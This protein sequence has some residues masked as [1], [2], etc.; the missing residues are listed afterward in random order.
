MDKTQ[1][2]ETLGFLVV[3]HKSLVP[4]VEVYHGTGAAVDRSQQPAASP[5]K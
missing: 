2:D 4:G 1:L 3:N 5:N